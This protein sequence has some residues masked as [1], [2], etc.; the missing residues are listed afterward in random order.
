MATMPVA[1][2][3][4]FRWYRSSIG[5]KAVMA[6]TGTLLVLFVIGHIA[7]NL[8]IF[9]GAAKIDAYGGFL[10]V[11]GAP[12]FGNEQLLWIIR[13]GL[14]ACV[15]LHI[16]AAVQLTAQNRAARPVR[17]ARKNELDAS[18]ASRT[19]RWGGAL[20]AV[21]IVFHILHFTTGTLHPDFHEGKVYTNVVT[22]FA[23]WP[24]AAAFYIVAMVA[25]GFHLYHGT[26]SMFQ[27]LGL[28][29]RQNHRPL[30][31]GATVLS[32]VFVLASVA[33]PVAVVAGFVK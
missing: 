9:E 21:F 12:V 20:I 7:G 28:R 10:R 14:L 30:R 17:Y 24:L 22:G 27:T 25:V 29:T 4:P 32:V 15:G 5:K 1:V 31:I 13:L 6:V 2:A 16:L 11:V 33:V 26:W 23:K 19:M 3:A 8:K 18:L